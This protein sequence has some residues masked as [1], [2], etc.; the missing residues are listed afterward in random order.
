MDLA[1][2][3]IG[4]EAQPEAVHRQCRLEHEE[5]IVPLKD[6][7]A[8]HPLYF[9]VRQPVTGAAPRTCEASS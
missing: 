9:V 1:G 3:A 4:I 8:G 6:L 5:P 2:V 7:M